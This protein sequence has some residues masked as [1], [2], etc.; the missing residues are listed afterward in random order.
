MQE[1][2]DFADGYK[3]IRGFSYGS[4]VKNPPA[5]QETRVQSPGGRHRKPLQDS[6]LD[7]PVDREGR[8]AKVHGV[9]KSQT[10]LK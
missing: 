2:V 9:G 1:I 7:N 3:D 6:Y 4:V 10:Q 8:W 5:L